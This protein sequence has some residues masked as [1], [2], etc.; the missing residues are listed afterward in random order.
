M[1]KLTFRQWE[2]FVPVTQGMAANCSKDI[3]RVIDYID[4]LA[5]TNDTVKQKEL[6]KQ[7]GFSDLSHF[8]DFA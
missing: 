7:F 1:K 8:A 3:G 6:Q 4:E 2:Y 5:V